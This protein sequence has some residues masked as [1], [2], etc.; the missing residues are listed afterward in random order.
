MA[1]KEKPGTA[2]P[3]RA[4]GAKLTTEERKRR[5]SELRAASMDHERQLQRAR[6]L[7]QSTVIHRPHHLSHHQHHH[8]HHRRHRHVDNDD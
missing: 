6:F 3:R 8:H 1:P 2:K 7:L 4:S 5:A